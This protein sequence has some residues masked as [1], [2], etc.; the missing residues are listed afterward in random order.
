[1]NKTVISIADHLIRERKHGI[2]KNMCFC[3]YFKYYFVF[4]KNLCI[5]WLKCC[6]KLRIR[7]ASGTSARLTARV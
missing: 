3:D 6:V 1:M 2:L 4:Q 5:P 7:K